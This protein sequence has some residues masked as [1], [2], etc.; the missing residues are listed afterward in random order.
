M[1][2]PPGSPREGQNAWQ[3]TWYEA[4]G[5]ASASEPAM[6][7]ASYRVLQRILALAGASWGSRKTDSRRKQ[8]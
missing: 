1:R 2:G 8:Y 3:H 6:P 7:G 5:I 4:P